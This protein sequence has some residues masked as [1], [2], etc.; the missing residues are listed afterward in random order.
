MKTLLKIAA[1]GVI[2]LSIAAWKTLNDAKKRSDMAAC[3]FN[4]RCLHQAAGQYR[5]ENK[6]NRGDPLDWNR[7]IGPGLLLEK[8]PVCPV[9][10]DYLLSPT[11]PETETLAAPC[12]DPGHR[13]GD[14]HKW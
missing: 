14:L 9:H 7:L 3:A 13:P 4:Q 12:R 5:K 2:L 1:A 6:L 10:G 8:E 11:V